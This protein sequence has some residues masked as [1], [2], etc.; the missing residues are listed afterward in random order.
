MPDSGVIEFLTTGR[1]AADHP[2]F[3]ELGYQDCLKRLSSTENKNEFT[4]PF[5]IA[6]AY[7][8]DAIPFT[9]YTFDFKGI[10]DYIFYSKTQMSVMGILGPIDSNWLQ[11]NKIAG[12]PHQ[13]VPS[14][15]LPLLVE[16][17]LTP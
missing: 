11:E 4:H 13:H 9:N 8:D 6:R 14:D 16:L 5:K 2:D 15:H 10:L 1:V 3:K 17:E 12:F 7:G